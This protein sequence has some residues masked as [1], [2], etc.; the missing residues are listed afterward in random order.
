MQGR[1]ITLG[2]EGVD[3]PEKSLVSK[4]ACCPLEF[5]SMDIRRENEIKTELSDDKR[6]NNPRYTLLQAPLLATPPR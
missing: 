5:K 1:R 3:A 4:E 2:V 6:G